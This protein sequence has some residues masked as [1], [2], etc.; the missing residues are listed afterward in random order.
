M[1]RAALCGMKPDPV[2]LETLMAAAGAGQPDVM[3]ELAKRLLVGKA[4]PFAPNEGLD[5]LSRAQ[6]L[7]ETEAPRI[8]ANLAAAG[9]WRP[10]SW[11]DAFDLLALAAERGSALAQGQLKL[12]ASEAGDGVDWRTLAARIDVAGWLAPPLRVPICEAPRMRIAK[13][14]VA[15][16]VCDWMMAQA[17]DKLQPAKMQDAYGADPHVS[18]ER[19]NSD[20]IIDIVEG[21]VVLT[22]VRA[23]I[24]AFIA[25]PTVAFQPPQV[26]HYLPGQELKPHFDFLQRSVSAEAAEEAGNQI[27]T[28]LVYLNDDYEGGETHFPRANIRHKGAKGDVMAFANVDPSGK[29]DTMTLHAGLPPTRGEKWLLSQWVRDRPIATG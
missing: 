27:M 24:S 28:V 25:L 9:A 21:D 1:A 3:T 6:A 29:P 12:L 7:G 8:A 20:F 14:F 15:P 18:V 5:L 10:Q 23:R 19:T 2:P 22:L 17:R 11:T 16:A 4:A 13:N 26:L